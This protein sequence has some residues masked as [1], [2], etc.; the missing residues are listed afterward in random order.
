MSINAVDEARQAQ[1]KLLKFEAIEQ[2]KTKKK[3]ELVEEA[4]KAIDG[5]IALN[6]MLKEQG[7]KNMTADVSEKEDNPS[8]IA[9]SAV[10]PDLAAVVNTNLYQNASSQMQ[11]DYR[12]GL[13]N[14]SS[15]RR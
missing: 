13:E 14:S 4:T 11:P 2:A 1:D 5:L 10:I 3:V 8:V 7:D 12:L 9:N 6:S 15:T